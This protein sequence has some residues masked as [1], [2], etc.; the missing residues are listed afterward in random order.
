MP[1]GRGP[2][3]PVAENAGDEVCRGSAGTPHI[4]PVVVREGWSSRGS[5]K[6]SV[7][8]QDML[9]YEVEGRHCGRIGSPKEARVAAR[10]K[11][12]YFSN[13][14]P[15]RSCVV[16]G[17]PPGQGMTWKVSGSKSNWSGKQTT[18]LSL[19]F[20]LCEECHAVSQN[21]P[22]AKLLSVLGVLM[23]IAICLVMAGVVGSG[24]FENSILGVAIGVALLVGLAIVVRSLSNTVNQ[25]DL[26]PNNARGAASFTAASG[27][28]D[29]RRRGSSTSRDGSCSTMRTPRSRLSFRP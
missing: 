5:L 17:N 18:T 13:F 19:E 4:V 14:N 2:A 26:T 12:H 15:P 8:G 24:A 21:R 23:G 29:S 28:L 16:C 11:T 7:V 3:G 20:P 10:V 1:C 25:R 27:S 6:R 9:V 22:L